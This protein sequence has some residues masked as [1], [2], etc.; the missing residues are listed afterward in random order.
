M[1]AA[2]HRMFHP[3]AD[4]GWR[5]KNKPGDTCH[6]T[7]YENRYLSLL[8]VLNAWFACLM[9]NNR[10]HCRHYSV[11]NGHSLPHDE[12]NLSSDKQIRN[13]TSGGMP[14]DITLIRI[15]WMAK[16]T[17]RKSKDGVMLGIRQG[18]T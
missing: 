6:Y 9:I 8:F 3:S 12:W 13:P 11:S 7:G 16:E 18:D 4:R 15:W 1:S 10:Q 2:R 17:A 14:L 5:R